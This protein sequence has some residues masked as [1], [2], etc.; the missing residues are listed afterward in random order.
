MKNCI[1]NNKHLY[2]IK[3]LITDDDKIDSMFGRS[4]LI[5]LEPILIKDI[6]LI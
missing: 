6:V 3:Y 4:K 2:V 5:F 1:D